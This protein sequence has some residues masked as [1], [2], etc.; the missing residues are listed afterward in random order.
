MN[1]NHFATIKPSQSHTLATLDNI[2]IASSQ[3]A[4][5]LTEQFK[6]KHLE[7]VIYFPLSDCKTEYFS[8]SASH[9]FCRIK[10]DASY[11]NITVNG[12][13]HKDAAWYYPTPIEGVKEIE[14]YVA[15]STQ[16]LTVTFAD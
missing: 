6:D 12:K 10:G 11:F 9:T 1:K 15:F 3:C 7:P 2:T 13:T 8:K 5:V 16:E 4:L 14:G